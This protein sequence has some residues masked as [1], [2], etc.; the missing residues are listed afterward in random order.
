MTQYTASTYGDRIADIYD[1]LYEKDHEIGPVVDV[2]A[3]LAGDGN[4]L[5]LG[6]GTGRIAIPLAARGV[7]VQG[8]DASNE[9]VLRLRAKEGSTS[10]PVTFGDFADVSVEGRFS[11]IFVMFNTFFSL[12]SQEDQVR[13]FSNVAS[14]LTAEGVFVLEAFV[15][16]LTRFV[17]GQNTATEFIEL[18]RV[19]LNVS[20]HDQMHQTVES[21]HVFLSEDR[22]RM[23][24]VNIR[25]AW[26]SELDLMAQL[27]GL[28]LR[29]RWSDWDPRPF[30]SS[31]TKHIS[32][33][34]RE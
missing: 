31:S 29:H 7:E 11:L 33:Y 34:E 15:P 12:Q 10:I 22:V 24:P 19:K 25:Y 17:R 30:T 5:E 6:I 27:A 4:A 16:D 32:I 3:E 18:D 8:I 14:R 1:D 21:Q 20:K 9:M 13:C 23:Y 28:R 2:L 26:P